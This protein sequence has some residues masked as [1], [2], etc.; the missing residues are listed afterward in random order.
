MQVAIVGFAT[1]GK[2]SA[3]YFHGLGHTVTICDQKPDLVA[4]Q[5][6]ETQ[7]G[8]T[9]LKNLA[10]FDL[11]VRTAGI[12]PH[13]ILEHNSGVEVKI[14]TAVNEFLAACPTKNVV[15]I[16]GTKGKGTT[17]TLTAKMLKAAGRKV[18]LGGNIGNSPLEFIDQ[19]QPDDW[20]VLELSSFQLSD[21][22]LSPHIAV[23]LMV[24]PEHLNWHTDMADYVAAKSNL[25]AR[26]T[27]DDVAVYFAENATSQEIAS[28]GDGKKLP[29]FAAPGAYVDN[30]QIVIDGEAICATSDLAL[31]GRHNW[32]NACAAVTA[33]W[34]AGVHD[35]AA[36]RSVVTTFSGL[37]HRLE[38]VRTMDGVQYYDDSFGTTPET[39][40]VAVQAFDQPKII[41]LGGSDK[42]A[43]YD[44]LAEVVSRSNVRKALLIGNQAPKIQLALEKAGFAEFLSGGNNMEDIV[45]TAR[46]VAQPGDVVLLSTGCASFDMFADY[47]DRGNQFTAAVQMLA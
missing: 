20:V 24:V 32:Q 27:H 19:I 42:G 41:I 39:A 26:Q 44:Q 18:W 3:E 28:H 46:Q 37:E 22:R 13:A 38:L 9:Y 40:M 5:G 47:K 17:S 23:C 6:F 8:D 4:P 35:L 30:N 12:P 11:I 31:R 25:F 16:T 10:R 21:L 33:V 14:T 36:I 1:E 43:S 29:F 45:K 7:L 15:G 34:Q 2:V